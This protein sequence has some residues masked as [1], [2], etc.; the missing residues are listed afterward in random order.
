MLYVSLAFAAKVFMAAADIVELRVDNAQTRVPL[1]Y[2][3]EVPQTSGISYLQPTRSI[4]VTNFRYENN[5]LLLFDLRNR[6]VGFTGNFLSFGEN[7]AP[8]KFALNYDDSLVSQ[9]RLWSCIDYEHNSNG[10][11]R[12]SFIVKGKN[13]PHS[14]CQ[15]IR[16]TRLTKCEKVELRAIALDGGLFSANLNTFREGENL[17]FLGEA[18]TGREFIYGGQQLLFDEVVDE[19]ITRVVQFFIHDRFAAVGPIVEP[20]MVRINEERE[21]VSDFLIW[22]CLNVNDPKQHSKMTRLIVLHEK[23]NDSCIQVVIRA[24]NTSGNLGPVSIS[25]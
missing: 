13:A 12:T 25:W 4:T 2:L 5:R 3:V 22:A 1:G 14:S 16:L 23:P 21:L 24:R 15:E 10:V 7:V 9:D 6:P 8:L 11:T 17:S 18:E 20:F 19:G